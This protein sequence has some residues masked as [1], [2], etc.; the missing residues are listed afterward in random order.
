MENLLNCKGKRFR[1]VIGDKEVE[2]KIQV[3][4]GCVYL[5]QDK[6]CGAGCEDKL[7]Y[8]GSWRVAYGSM[9]DLVREGVEDFQLVDISPS[10][11]KDWQVGDKVLQEDAKDGDSYGEVIFRSGELVVLKFRSGNAS[12]N[13]TCDELFRIGFRLVEEKE[14]VIELTL[15][16]VAKMK[17]VSVDRIRIKE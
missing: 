16:D 14:D 6:K 1:A 4:E 13:F 7:G 9:Y 2:G 10:E 12:G 15:D 8:K 3:E 11:Y 17:G 5:C